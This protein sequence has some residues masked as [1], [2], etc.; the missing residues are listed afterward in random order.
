MVRGLGSTGLLR[1]RGVAVGIE[2]INLKEAIRRSGLH[3]NLIQRLLRE[4]VLDRYKT[5][6]GGSIPG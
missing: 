5:G 4:G 2:Y 3:S 1:G 6:V